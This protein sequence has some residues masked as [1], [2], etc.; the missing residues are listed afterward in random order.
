MYIEKNEDVT[1]NFVINTNKAEDI[2]KILINNVE[3]VATKLDADTYQV[4]YNV[5]NTSGV[6]KLNVTQLTYANG[7]TFDVDSEIDVEVLK[8]KPSI[9]GFIQDNNSNY[10]KVTLEFNVL[11]KDKAFIDGKA[12]LKN[13]DDNS[14]KEA[15]ITVGKNTVE[16]QVS[17]RKAI[18]FRNLCYL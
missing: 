3:C 6:Q 11:D 14:T 7:K 12:V 10:D 16:F 15:T 17:R 1:L 8:D 18:Y 4:T 9:D 2:E 13:N 5:G